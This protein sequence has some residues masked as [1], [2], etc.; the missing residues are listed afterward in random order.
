MQEGNAETE[1]SFFS[2]QAQREPG[3][4]ALRPTLCVLCEHTCVYGRHACAG[5]CVCVCVKGSMRVS[6]NDCVCLC[7]CCALRGGGWNLCSGLI[8]SLS[9]CMKCTHC[10]RMFI[11]LPA[12]GRWPPLWAEGPAFL[13]MAFS[14]PDILTLKG[15]PER[16]INFKTNF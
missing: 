4:S 12:T 5:V 3:P 16:H 2:V 6:V 11:C 8:R 13:P 7:M 9:T 14:L 1:M 15:K 10:P